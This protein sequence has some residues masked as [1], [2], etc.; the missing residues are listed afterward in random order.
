[1]KLRRYNSYA[2]YDILIYEEIAPRRYGGGSAHGHASLLKS[3]GTVLSC[4]PASIAI[5]LRPTIWKR[6]VSKSYVK[7][8]E[9]DA[10]EMGRIAI[11]IAR[12]YLL[13]KEEK[14]SRKKSKS[15]KKDITHE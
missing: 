1:M 14:A 6:L 3:V 10:M 13:E 11:E 5:G 7:S 15:K 9:A 8:D 4:A 12:G 2:N